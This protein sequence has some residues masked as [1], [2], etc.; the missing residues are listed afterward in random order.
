[1]IPVLKV[2]KIN[3]H[4]ECVGTTGCYRVIPEGI[5]F[6]SSARSHTE[7]TVDKLQIPV[8][9]IVEDHGLHNRIGIAVFFIC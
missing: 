4:L 9:L 8:H 2:Y 1:M 5:T 7:R 3:P 6:P